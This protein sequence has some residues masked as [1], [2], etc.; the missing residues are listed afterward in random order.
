MSE[1][2][3]KEYIV[4]YYD[5]TQNDQIDLGE[6]IRY[7]QET[8]TQHT[9]KLGCGVEYLN[10]NRYGWV[11]LQNHIKTYRYPKLNEKIIVRTWVNN[12]EKLYALRHYEIVDEQ[13]NIVLQS[14]TRWI[15]YSFERL[16]PIKIPQEVTDMFI[17]SDKK[18][19]QIDDVD[20]KN[21]YVVTDKKESVVLYKDIDTNWHMNNVAYIKEALQTM[22]KDFL[23]CNEV[24]ECLVEYRHQLL[25]NEKFE[26]DVKKVKDN[27]YIYGIKVNESGKM[28]KNNNADIY[29]KWRKKSEPYNQ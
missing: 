27:E 16:R 3:E 8:S 24:C 7:M 12:M 19:V 6:L 15:L 10:K 13:G 28:Q 14:Y 20:F 21:E 5:C 9:S 11:L 1:V 26:I 4:K 22:G 29:I 23:D 2:F 17:Y 25:Y 18:T